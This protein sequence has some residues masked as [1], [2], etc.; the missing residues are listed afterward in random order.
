MN[1]EMKATRKALRHA[2]AE[3]AV[4]HREAANFTDSKNKLLADLKMTVTD[5]DKLLRDAAASSGDQLAAAM[6]CVET[7]VDETRDKLGRVTSA[8]GKKAGQAVDAT[9]TYVRKNP[10]RS[11][12]IIAAAGLLAGMLLHRSKP[13]R[14]SE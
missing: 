6:T 10:W 4:S 5:A 7:K 8:A 12:G 2:I 3:A 14:T 9:S 13:P 1:A 11:A